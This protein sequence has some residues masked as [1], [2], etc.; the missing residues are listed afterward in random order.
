MPSSIAYQATI[1]NGQP[2]A[3]KWLNDTGADVEVGT[4]IKKGSIFGIVAGG[5]SQD[6]STKVLSTVYGTAVFTP[7]IE[8][9]L[10]A[11]TTDSY[12]T[13][14]LIYWDTSNARLSSSAITAGAGGKIGY[15]AVSKAA[16]V[17]TGVIMFNQTQVV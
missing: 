2:I 6:G 8:V 11:F 5:N 12:A 7:G 3:T 9:L 14:T 4:V 13:G 15:T 17:A 16:G 1:L 10:P